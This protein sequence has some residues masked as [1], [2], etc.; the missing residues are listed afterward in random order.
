M[1]IHEFAVRLCAAGESIEVKLPREGLV[2]DTRANFPQDIRFAPIRY[3]DDGITATLT[4]IVRHGCSGTDCVGKTFS[5]RM[6]DPKTEEVPN[7]NTTTYVYYGLPDERAFWTSQVII[8]PSVKVIRKGAFDEGCCGVRRVIMHRNVEVIEDRAFLEC[9]CL[10]SVF[11]PPS[12]KKIGDRA[13]GGCENMRI[14]SVP[15]SI[16]MNTSQI[17]KGFLQGCFDYFN[18]T[19][20]PYD[21][22]DWESW[23]NNEEIKESFMNF[24]RNLHPLYQVCMDFDVSAQ[25]IREC[26]ATHGPAA[27]YST[28]YGD[29]MT[30]MHILV[31]NPQ[32]ADDAGAILTLFHANMSAILEPYSYFGNG[33]ATECDDIVEEANA[34]DDRSPLECLMEI[35][36]DTHLSVIAALCKHREAHHGDTNKSNAGYMSKRQKV[37]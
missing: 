3:H 21:E 9:L 23:D 1:F 36:A 17:G 2:M 18:M 37:H 4:R 7:F 6:F 16:A 5:M 15:Q 27:A 13:F 11:L 31:L 22:E 35:N 25:S 20:I 19:K 26:I 29:G 8:H 28:D 14:L 33:D 24:H 34:I 30:P 12:I 10:H 32:A